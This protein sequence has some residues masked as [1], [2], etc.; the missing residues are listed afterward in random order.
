M[1]HPESIHDEEWRTGWKSGDETLRNEGR[2]QLVCDIVIPL[3]PRLIFDLGC[4]NGYQ[5]EK[6]KNVLPDTHIKGCDISSVA[7]E[8]ASK[9]MDSCYVLDIDHNSLPENSECYDLVLCIA[10]LEHLYNVQHALNEIYRILKHGSHAL[11][12]VPNLS[13]WRFR[14]DLMRGNLPY[15]L[16]D[17]RH[18]HSFNKNFLIHLLM[19]AGFRDFHIYGQRNRIKWLA[20]LCP[21]I[22]SEDIF[23]IA[24]KPFSIP[25]VDNNSR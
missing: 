8:K 14:L 12:Q 7:I 25:K 22:F 20:S 4:G 10:V 16:K 13:F 21:H 19:E 15:I 11:I 3:S 2:F 9:I 24:K 23:V 17:K 6:L 1:K 18:L 5:A